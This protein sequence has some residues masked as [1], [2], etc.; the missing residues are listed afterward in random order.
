MSRVVLGWFGSRRVGF[1][2]A[3]PGRAYGSLNFVAADTE[4]MSPGV[5]TVDLDALAGNYRALRKA[6]AQSTCGAVVKANAYGLGVGPVA[7]RLWEEGCRHFFVSTAR[8]GAEL[9]ALLP[10]ARIYVFEGVLEGGAGRVIDSELIPVL[11]TVGQIRH[12]RSVGAGRAAAIH[13]DT[14]MSRLGLTEAEVREVS[15]TGLLDGLELRYALTHLA[16]ADVPSHPLNSRQAHSFADLLTLLPRVET[17]IGGSAGILLGPEYQ[18]DLVRPGIALYGGNPFA[19]STSPMEP[20]VTLEGVVLQTRTV[21]RQRTVGYGA[22]HTVRSGA[23]LATVGVGFADGYPRT[24]GNRGVAFAAGTEVPV[25]GRVSMDLITLDVSGLGP[26][27]AQPGDTVEL[28]G[29]NVLL[30]DLARAAGTIG[31]E[32]LTGLGP[33]WLRRY[34]P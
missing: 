27:A 1:G 21:T 18:G 9:R 24:L 23:R 8:E 6:A 11:N 30:D 12:W 5:L 15:R 34:L 25:V 28:L 13:L 16:C 10:E 4:M 7:G 19:N 32:V 26:E 31:Y 29:R 3:G 20:V 22:T 33:R 17:S 2:G 14:G